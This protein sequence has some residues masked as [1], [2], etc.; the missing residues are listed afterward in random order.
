MPKKITVTFADDLFDS[1]CES[2]ARAHG[3]KAEV[4][5]DGE[6]VPNPESIAAH[7]ERRISEDIAAKHERMQSRIA[8]DAT[9]KET[10]A[11][12]REQLNPRS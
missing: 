10:R 7:L 4:P 6:L 11:R 2:Y 3:W 9:E 1:L 8:I 5:V 12:T